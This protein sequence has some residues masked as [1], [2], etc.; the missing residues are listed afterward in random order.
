MHTSEIKEWIALET[1]NTVK[2]QWEIK[3]ILCMSSVDG[4]A[5]PPLVGGL[6]AN[7]HAARFFTQW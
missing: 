4:K 2:R 3:H 7:A 5:S 1:N 6:A